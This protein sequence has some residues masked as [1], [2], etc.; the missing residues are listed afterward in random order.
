MMSVKL[1]AGSCLE[2]T[3]TV[4]LYVGPQARLLDRLGQEVDL[5]AKQFGQTPLQ[6]TKRKKPYTG[7]RIQLGGKVNVAVRLGIAA[8][9]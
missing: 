7:L 3:P 6:G 1:S 9:D 2:G 5:A 4:S 8:R